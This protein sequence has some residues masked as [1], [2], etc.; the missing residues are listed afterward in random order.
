M[1]RD[2]PPPPGCPH[3]LG[4]AE[5]EGAAVEDE[6]RGLEPGGGQGDVLLAE[7]EVAVGVL[8]HAWRD[9]ERLTVDAVVHAGG[10]VGRVAPVAAGVEDER[11]VSG[12]GQ[13]RYGTADRHAT[14]PTFAILVGLNQPATEESVA[15]VFGDDGLG[16]RG[17]FVHR[18]GAARGRWAGWT[19]RGGVVATRGAAQA[20][21]ERNERNDESTH[22]QSIAAR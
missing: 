13:L 11:A 5:F 18:C 17:R 12:E 6:H 4:G 19:R 3:P 20:E 22:G 14:E 7:A 21:E 15:C 10:A 16:R 8:G 1:R 2:P 9:R